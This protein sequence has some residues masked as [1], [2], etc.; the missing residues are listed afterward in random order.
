ML[1][2]MAAP[3]CA[4]HKTAAMAIPLQ[5]SDFLAVNRAHRVY[6]RTRSVVGT[7]TV[8]CPQH[9]LLSRLSGPRLA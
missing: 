6:L 3:T 5:K 7:A 9:E 8:L 1:R 4:I 2:V